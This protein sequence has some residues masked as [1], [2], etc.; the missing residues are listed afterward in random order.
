MSAA[1]I[2]KVVIVLLLIIIIISLSSGMI[3]LVR[4]KGKSNR[5]VKS[6]TIRIVLSIFLFILLFIGFRAGW[7]QPHGVAPEQ[8]EKALSR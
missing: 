2:F 5:T 8:T 4:D 3:F 7:I 6:L 1:F